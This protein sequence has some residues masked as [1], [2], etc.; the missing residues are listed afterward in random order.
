MIMSSEPADKAADIPFSEGV[1]ETD[2]KYSVAEVVEALDLEYSEDSLFQL[3]GYSDQI[4]ELTG[5]SVGK[6]DH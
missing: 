2:P 6:D 1:Q 3:G 4:E 5:K